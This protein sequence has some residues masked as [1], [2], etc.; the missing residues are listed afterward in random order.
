M[1]STSAAGGAANYHEKLPLRFAILGPSV[2]N[3]GAL[4]RQSGI[5]TPDIHL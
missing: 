1:T 5:P 2:E 3:S 4:F